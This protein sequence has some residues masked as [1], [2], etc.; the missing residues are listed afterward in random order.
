MV[1]AILTWCQ[2]RSAE[3]GNRGVCVGLQLPLR[4]PWFHP[5]DVMEKKPSESRGPCQEPPHCAPPQP[6]PTSPTQPSPLLWAG[7][8]D[9][10]PEHA[11]INRSAPGGKP[12]FRVTMPAASWGDMSQSQSRG[13]KAGRGEWG[14]GRSQ[15]ALREWKAG[16]Y[17]TGEGED[18]DQSTAK[19]K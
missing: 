8:G 10:R 19:D 2:A 9:S 1:T 6:A 14:T 15:L 4:L 13:W 11:I 5:S 16:C 3:L 12:N 7:Q 17:S 18:K